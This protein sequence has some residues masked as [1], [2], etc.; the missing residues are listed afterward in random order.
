MIM[1]FEGDHSKDHPSLWFY[2]FCFL[3]LVLEHARLRVVVRDEAEASVFFHRKHRPS[4]SELRAKGRAR[5]L[6]SRVVGRRR[7]GRGSPSQP[8]VGYHCSTPVPPSPRA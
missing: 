6:W 1:G 8:S 7:E 3:S 2:P 5:L 4:P